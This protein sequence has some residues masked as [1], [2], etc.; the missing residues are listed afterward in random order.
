[1]PAVVVG[2]ALAAIAVVFVFFRPGYQPKGEDSLLK[3]DMSRYPAPSGGWTWAAGQPGFRFGVHEEEWNLSGVQ[4][5]DLAPAHAAARRWGVAPESVRLV[6]AI[7]LG[8][9]DVNLIVAGTDA[10]DHTCLGFVVTDE[11]VEFFCSG[12]LSH[13][14]AVLLVLRPS[15]AGGGLFVEGI[16]SAAVTKVVIEDGP[17]APVFDRKAGVVSYWG[18]FGVS[19]MDADSVTITLS[20]ETGTPVRKTVDTTSDGDQ[21][22]PIPG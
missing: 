19:L 20:R 15:Y 3:V 12:R 5:A 22:I 9:H 14:S 2:A 7:R 13:V 10:S 18:T 21:I 17:G 8:P 4:G 6:D 1:M 16:S 11:P